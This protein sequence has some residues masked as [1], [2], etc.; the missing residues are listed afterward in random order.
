MRRYWSDPTNRH[1]VR[2]GAATLF[3]EL[4]SS[5]EQGVQLEKH[6]FNNTIRLVDQ[7][8]IPRNWNVKQF[9]FLYFAKVRSLRY[10]LAKYSKLLEDVLNRRTTYRTLVEMTPDELRGESVVHEPILSHTELLDSIPDGAFKCRRCQSRKTTY[11][12][13]QTRCADEPMTVFVTCMNCNN[14]WKGG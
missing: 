2:S 5:E 7:R 6:I 8:K 14:R 1:E 11:Y 13:M 9:R 3:S 12:E 4:L 10:N